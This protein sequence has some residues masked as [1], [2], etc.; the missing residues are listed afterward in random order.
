MLSLETPY[1]IRR[2]R[3]SNCYKKP[4]MLN[5]SCVESCT[6]FINGNNIDCIDTIPP[7]KYILGNKEV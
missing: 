2:K 5:G 1:S 6:V 7:N 4:Y 3:R